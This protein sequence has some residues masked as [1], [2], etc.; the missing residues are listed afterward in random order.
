LRYDQNEHYGS[1]VNPRVGARYRFTDWLSARGAVGRGFRAPTFDELF[2]PDTGFYAGNPNLK[3]EENWSY[4][5]GAEFAY[6]G[7]GTSL[8]VTYFR[9]DYS[10]LIVNTA[11]DDDPYLLKPE[12]VAEALISGIEAGGETS[13]LALFGVGAP[14]L[15]VSASLTH[16]LEAKGTS[17]GGEP[18][19]L[20]YR[21]ATSVF[22]EFSYVQPLN[23]AFSVVSEFNVRYVS[24]SQYTY[25]DPYT[26]EAEKRFLEPY[27]LAGT[28]IAA[29]FFGVEPYF[30]VKNLGDVAYQTIYDYSMP[31]RTFA[32]GV[33]FSY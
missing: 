4:E 25:V 3:P 24:R 2:W 9:S 30:A 16:L 5:G 19:G 18:E 8:E 32:G 6:P 11:D 31:G 10:N 28:R 1:Q 21:P 29:R 33:T 15:G 12:N 14:Q 13:P 17:D 22:L 20:D 27:T 26:Y 7:K 23:G